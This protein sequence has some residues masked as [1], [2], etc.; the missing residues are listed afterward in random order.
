MKL[1]LP[2]WFCVM[3][4]TLSAAVADLGDRIGKVI[5]AE[6]T[7]RPV[8]VVDRDASP[9]P[10]KFADERYIVVVLKL[11]ARRSLSLLDYALSVNG[12]KYPCIAA[13]RNQEPFVAN[14]EALYSSGDDAARL[15][16]AVDGARVKPVDGV[17]TA[18]L[19]PQLPGR[20]AVTFQITDIGNRAFTD[21][22]AIPADGL[23]PK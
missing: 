19:T 14:P 10:G 4:V 11:D 12:V 8:D 18:T 1:L 15:L 6:F 22:G 9:A 20:R 5:A 13:V 21:P 3:A 2:A 7:S 23:L 16:F 17:L